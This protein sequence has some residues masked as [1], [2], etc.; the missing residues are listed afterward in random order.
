MSSTDHSAHWGYTDAK[1]DY[2]KRMARIEGQARGITRMIDEDKYC[3][4]ILTQIS[5]LTRALQ[6]VGTGLLDDHLKH[7]V[8]DAAKSGDDAEAAAKIQEAM[9]AVKRLVRS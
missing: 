1:A 8:L 4:D 3:I 2:L 7:C 5:A 9:D 6:V